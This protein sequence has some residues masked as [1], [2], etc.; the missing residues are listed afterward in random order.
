VTHVKPVNY[1]AVAPTYDRRYERHPYDDIAACLRT[2]LAG[3]TGAVAEIGCGTG[4]WLGAA[5]A[6]G[7]AKVIG[8]DVSSGMLE[9]A[10]THAPAA[11]LVR[12]TAD[13]LPWADAC[14][15]RVFCVNALHHFPAPAAFVAECRRV[16]RPGGG[17]LTIGLDPHRGDDRW[18]VYDVFPS[19][20]PAD[21]AR[22]PST[23]TI[24][25]RL[26]AAGFREITTE[27]AQRI[28]G[29]LSFD[30]ARSGGFLERESTSQLMVIGDD[31]YERGIR[32]LHAE[33]PVLQTD[34]RLYATM[35]WT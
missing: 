5:A 15:D 21:R 2:F 8:V 17:V 26:G 3:G 6:L 13:H 22:Y 20:A 7:Q 11:L 34:L 32:R 14:L 30:A 16:L 25:A 10:R 1:D 28:A 19:A 35:A 23:A 4:H 31:E 12:A 33:Q 27:V 29:E 24:R 9:R 18:W